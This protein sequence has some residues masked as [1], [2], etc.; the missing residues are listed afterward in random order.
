MSSQMSNQYYPDMVSPPG[1][2]LLETIE[3]MGM[4][5]AELSERMGRPKKTINEI[6]KGKTAITPETALQLERVLGVPASFWNN[7]ERQYRENLARIQERAIL[8]SQIDWLKLFP[9]KEMISCH[10]VKAS[11][12]TIEQLQELLNF[13]GVATPNEWSSLWS[14]LPVAFRQ[15]TAYSADPGSVAA[16]LRK[17]E[18]DAQQIECSPFTEDKFRSALSDI[19]NL[20]SE[21]PKV[22]VPRIREA[23][24]RAGVAVVFVKELPRIRTSGATRWLTPSKALLQLSLRYKSDDQLFFTL[25]HESAHILLHGKREIFLEDDEKENDKENEADRFAADLL[26]PPEDYS[27][28][29]PSKK[30]YSKQD[31]LDFASRIGI[32][33]G[34]V[35]GRLQHDGK[36]RPSFC[37]DLKVKLV[38]SDDVTD[39]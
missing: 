23:C 27:Q 5:Q 20:T 32:A 35:V 30:Y 1:E 15:S 18:L 14:G 21:S 29:K 19:R 13:F 28:F 24:A 9:L 16:W 22:F 10:W 33:P 6:I 26:I 11:D 17:G 7:R 8:Q 34:I 39:K 2:T 38:W 3:A 25:F 4:S 36:L 37:N 12:S 31:I